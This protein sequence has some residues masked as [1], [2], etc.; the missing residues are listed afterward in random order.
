MRPAHAASILAGIALLL[1]AA[2]CRRRS[3]PTAAPDGMGIVSTRTE[4]G[5]RDTV[6]FA[7]TA[8]QMADAW[9][10]SGQGP[11]PEDLLGGALPAGVTVVG[12]ICP[13]DDYLYAGRVYRR[14]VPHITARRVLL[15]GV[16]HGWRRFGARDKLVF[17]TFRT[18]RTPDGPLLVSRLRD[19][20]LA[21]LPHAVRVADP[22]MHDSEH[23]VEAVAYWLRHQRPDLELIPV[24]VPVMGEARMRE[25]AAVLARTL[26]TIM[27]AHGLALGRDLAVGIS[28][29]GVHYG[30]DFSHTPFGEGGVEAYTRAVDNDRGVL[31][32]L[33]GEVSD[34]RAHFAVSTF[35]DPADP[36]RYRL[37]WCGRFSIPFGLMLMH[38]LAA[39]LG[40]PAVELRPVAYATSVGWPELPVRTPGLG[41][42][43]PANLYHF[44]GYPA[45]LFTMP[46]A[47]PAR[48]RAG[49]PRR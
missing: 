33:A 16:F 18:W 35:T 13:H 2:A 49:E 20:L 36:G 27:R 3:A 8:A 40:R 15:I 45:A 6:G 9:R 4:R 5:Q 28:S 47:A 21:R 23:S 25:L 34:E 22:A 17:D 12:G 24:L 44:V 1:P 7:S 14:L 39:A 41:R 42:T 26:A 19:E 30:A 37:T 10:A 31:R 32:S 11:P 38:R 48:P 29:D 43:A 46:A